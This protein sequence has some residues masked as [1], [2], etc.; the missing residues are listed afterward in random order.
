MYGSGVIGRVTMTRT[1]FR[2]QFGYQHNKNQV[3]VRIPARALVTLI[4]NRSA[5]NPCPKRSHESLSMALTPAHEAVKTA[6]GIGVK[7]GRISESTTKGEENE[8]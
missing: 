8:Q 1:N 5:V 2:L 4:T 3:R 7:T 6:L